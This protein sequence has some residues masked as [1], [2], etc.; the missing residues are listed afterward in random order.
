MK[1]LLDIH[2]ENMATN[3][4]ILKILGRCTMLALV[5]MKVMLSVKNIPDYL[6]GQSIPQLHYTRNTAT[7]I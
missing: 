6:D 1:V 3:Y 2:S 5:G 7:A 4:N